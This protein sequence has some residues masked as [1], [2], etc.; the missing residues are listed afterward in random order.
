L[1]SGI[2]RGLTVNASEKV[3]FHPCPSVFG[4]ACEKSDFIRL[5]GAG[6][7]IG[8]SAFNVRY[9]WTTIKRM[10][11]GSLDNIMVRLFTIFAVCF[12][13]ATSLQTLA[14]SNLP[15][16][17]EL[18]PQLN[19]PGPQPNPQT[20]ADQP[21]S[22]SRPC[23]PVLD[24]QR[25]KATMALHGAFTSEISDRDQI[26][27]ILKRIR[28]LGGLTPKAETVQRLLVYIGKQNALFAYVQNNEICSANSGPAKSSMMLL[29]SVIGETV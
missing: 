23:I 9:R 19:V 14:T 13:L 22:P 24:A 29:Y 2:L 15:L 28:A 26:G 17:R 8:T 20:A 5:T 21:S 1:L 16:T 11:A 10:A 18:V 27:R 3:G 6:T 25:F 7:L 4:F 12:V